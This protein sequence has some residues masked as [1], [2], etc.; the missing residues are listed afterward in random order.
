MEFTTFH[1]ERVRELLRQRFYFVRLNAE[2]REDIY[3]GGRKFVFRP[4]GHNT[5]VHELAEALA[6]IEGKLN[7]PAICLIDEHNTIVFQY[8]GL[9]KIREF[10]NLLNFF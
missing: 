6:T 4:N 8:G 9:L 10:L 3:F 2:S 7:Y 5:G 1:D